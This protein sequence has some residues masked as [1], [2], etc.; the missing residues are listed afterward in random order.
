M[1]QG[2]L[3]AVMAATAVL[4]LPGAAH[5]ADYQDAVMADGPL[6]YWRLDELSGT[7]AQDATANDRDGTYANA[8]LGAAAPFVAAG[9]AV[10][11]PKTGTV[12]GTVGA[13]SGSVELWVN[14]SKLRRGEQ[15][16]IAAHGDPA[17]DGWTLGIGVKRKVAWKHAG[18]TA[19][20]KITLAN[21][22][23]TQLTVTWDASKVRFYVNGTAAKAVNNTPGV[24]ASSSG[25]FVVGGNGAGAFTGALAGKVDEDAL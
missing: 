7:V 6:S 19:Q 14:P 21:G 23:W 10:T 13:T 8:T 15:A 9:T 4:A 3:A 2:T 22:L 1:K 12:A 11:L 5:A 17:G 16:G 25:A 24:P 20:S 18:A